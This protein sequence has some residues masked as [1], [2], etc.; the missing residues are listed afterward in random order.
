MK[1]EF[2]GTKGE[3]IARLTENDP[4]F[5]A[6]VDEVTGVY[7]STNTEECEANAKLIAAAPDLLEAL[8]LYVKHGVI[9]G[10]VKENAIKAINKAL[11]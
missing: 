4:D 1:K 8:Q 7:R 5:V 3:W 11:K 2:K 9:F 6:E 10:Q